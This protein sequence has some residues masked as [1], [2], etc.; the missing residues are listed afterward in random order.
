MQ[1]R[2]NIQTDTGSAEEC[3]GQGHAEGDPQ[4]QDSLLSVHGPKRTM[5]PELRALEAR[6]G[7][8]GQSARNMS[9]LR[10]KRNVGKLACLLKFCDGHT[11]PP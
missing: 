2:Q 8:S 7:A 3:D 5:R 4:K 6:S 10:V 9:I 11:A 1:E